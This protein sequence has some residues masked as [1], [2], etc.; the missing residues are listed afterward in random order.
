MTIGID[1]QGHIP[2]VHFQNDIVES[3]IKCLE[4]IARPILMQSNLPTFSCGHIIL[5]SASLIR[6]CPFAFNS[7]TPHHLAFGMILNVS[8]LRTFGCQILV[9]ITSPKCTMMGPH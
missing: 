4:M 5:H 9:P 1:I 2:Y 3:L 8:R 7:L 6:Y